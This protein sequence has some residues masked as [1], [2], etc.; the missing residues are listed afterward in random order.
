MECSDLRERCVE[1]QAFGAVGIR[2]GQVKTSWELGQEALGG[3]CS[4]FHGMPVY[5][6]ATEIWKESS[7]LLWVLGTRDYSHGGHSKTTHILFVTLMG[8]SHLFWI[9]TVLMFDCFN[10][11]FSSPRAGT[12]ISGV[13]PLIPS[14]ISS[15]FV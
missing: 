6:T 9:T 12:W 2:P 5:L 7:S 1:R 14:G 13:I 15:S 10:K 3:S 11:I 8:P 4:F